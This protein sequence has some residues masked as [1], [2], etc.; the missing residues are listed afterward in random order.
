MH[1]SITNVPCTAILIVVKG[2]STK[3]EACSAK[4]QIWSAE[5]VHPLLIVAHGLASTTPM[6]ILNF[7]NAVQEN[8]AS[9]LTAKSIAGKTKIVP[10]DI[11][12]EKRTGIS[13]LKM[14]TAERMRIVSMI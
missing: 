8:A 1:T 10:Q 4:S 11:A 12:M 7:M 5:L 2:P 13:T 6:I 14:S 9:Q 3:R